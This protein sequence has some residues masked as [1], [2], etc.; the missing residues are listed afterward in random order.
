MGDTGIEDF[1]LEFNVGGWVEDVGKVV[2]ED[3]S[4][5]RFLGVWS[6]RV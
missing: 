5:G 4:L 3:R 6:V 1:C 2:G